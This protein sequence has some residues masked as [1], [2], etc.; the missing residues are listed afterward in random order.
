MSKLEMVKALND[1][2][3]QL[4]IVDAVRTLQQTTQQMNEQISNLPETISN[5]TAKALEPLTVINTE[6]QSVPHKIATETAK[7]L[8][9]LTTI[10][11]ELRSLPEA[12]AKEA[13]ISL[14]PLTT[15]S[16]KVQKALI[17]YDEMTAA[18]R[19]T[20]EILT[21][22]Q[23]KQISQLLA[24]ISD[25]AKIIAGTKTTVETM[26]KSIE[27]EIE[28]IDGVATKVYDTAH[29]NRPTWWKPIL[30]SILTG[31][32]AAII[33]LTGQNALNRLLPPSDV[34]KNSEILLLLSSKMTDK[35][36]ALVDKI[37]N[38]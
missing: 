2:G 34:Q 19:R 29:A 24:P 37:L 6:L 22:Q 7:V 32:T 1:S 38:R 35:E 26:V 18:M 28:R 25:N 17:S 10:S 9:P 20:L 3:P 5:E 16:D 23:Q 11:Q 14:E 21:V 27:T 8:E 30:M 36:R 15:I 33:V 4:M 12:I 13:S 31:T